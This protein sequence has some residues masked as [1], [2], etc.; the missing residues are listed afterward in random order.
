MTTR[1]FTDTDAVVDRFYADLADADLQPLWMQERLMSASP[2]LGALPHVWRWPSM[3]ALG[4]AAEHLIP[5][6]RGG[7]RRVLALSNPGLDGLPYATPTIWAAVQ[8]LGAGERAPAHRHSPSA[9]RFVLEG[10]GAVTF[11]DDHS[12]RMAAGDLVVTPAWGWHAHVNA[13]ATSLSWFDG[14]DLP[15]VRNLDAVFFETHDDDR[16][17]PGAGYWPKLHFPRGDTAAALDGLQRRHPEVPVG[18][19]YV[20]PV[21]GRDAMPTLRSRM[22]RLPAG[23]AT[24]ST[25]RAGSAVWVTFAGDVAITIDGV[26]LTASAGDIFVV[27]SWAVLSIRATV[28]AELFELSDAPVLEAFGLD[29]TE[30]IDRTGLAAPVIADL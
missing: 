11:V 9:L 26:E 5:I 3:R 18:V 20:D 6:D 13:T 16:P 4:D 28:A 15:I 10:S 17:L 29:R 12:I 8:F 30:L 23:S 19:R 21:S 25:R 7:D 1:V 2:P 27:P 14:L 24:P 22:L